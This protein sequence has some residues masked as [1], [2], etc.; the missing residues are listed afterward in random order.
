MKNEIKLPRQ[1]ED[2]EITEEIGSGAY[3]KVYKVKRRIG[4]VESCSAVKVV[5]IPSDF[6]EAE[7]IARD[8]PDMEALQD[9]YAKLVDD[10]VREIRAMVS[11]EGLTNIVSIEDYVIEPQEEGIGANIFIR[12]EYL[13]SFPE[14]ASS[15]KMTEID[16][17]RLG[18]D[19]CR[20]LSYCEEIQLVHRDIKPDNIFVS[21]HGDFKLGDFGIAGRIDNL[22][23]TASLRGTCTYMAPEVFTEQIYNAK[24]DL[25]SLGLVLYRLVNNNKDAFI[26]PM[27]QLVYSRD[28]EEALKRRLKGEPLPKPFNYSNEMF[29]VLQKACAYRP[30]DR[31]HSA[32]EM[33]KALW[34]IPKKESAED[35]TE[36]VAENSKEPESKL[37]VESDPS[38]QIP[39]TQEKCTEAASADP[40]ALLTNED[41]PAAK[42]KKG[43]ETNHGG[44]GGISKIRASVFAAGILVVLF[45]IGLRLLPD[46]VQKK[47]TKTEPLEEAHDTQQAQ[48]RTSSSEYTYLSELFDAGSMMKT[49]IDGYRRVLWT[50]EPEDAQALLTKDGAV[51]SIGDFSGEPVLKAVIKNP[52]DGIELS[53]NYYY[54][55]KKELCE[56]DAVVRLLSQRDTEA[57][58]RVPTAK[59]DLFLRTVELL[60]LFY[61]EPVRRELVSGK[62]AAGWTDEDGDL[63]VIFS[64]EDHS[65]EV[66]IIAYHPGNDPSSE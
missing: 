59:T 14:Y 53:E 64:G 31:F 38:W 48:N 44:H 8:L 49:R 66:S 17:A 20:A 16:V 34:A 36:L 41:R 25:Y 4:Q 47:E 13:Q 22:T 37:S 18:I 12:M 24:T 30:E 26:N 10:Y 57:E 7:Y 15:K 55:N 28:R 58:E 51:C 23:K 2:W 6:S 19:M 61:G 43:D 39:I 40:F 46:V 42:R 1:W 45:I 11:L 3:G 35:F 21:K 65:S 33:K 32:M 63:I 60:K 62:R 50:M 5:P 9:Y 54:S 29:A 56:V 27:K 52:S